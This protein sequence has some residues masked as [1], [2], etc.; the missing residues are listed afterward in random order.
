MVQTPVAGW[1]GETLVGVS[2]MERVGIGRQ[3]YNIY[4]DNRMGRIINVIYYVRVFQE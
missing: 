4:M 1:N 3:L 2:V